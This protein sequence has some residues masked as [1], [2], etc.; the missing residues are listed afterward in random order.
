MFSL[1]RHGRNMSLPRTSLLR[2]SRTR[3]DPAI[4]AVITN[5]IHRRIIDHCCV[6]DVVNA[7]HIDIVHRAVVVEASIVPAAAL[8]A[9]SEVPVAVIDATIESYLRAPIA[10]VE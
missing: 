8:V 3:V 6:V 5:A 9:F 1:S 7:C 4:A 10:F 2:R